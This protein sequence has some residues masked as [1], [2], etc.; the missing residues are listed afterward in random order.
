MMTALSSEVMPGQQLPTGS[1]FWARTFHLRIVEMIDNRKKKKKKPDNSS[2][3]NGLP[4]CKKPVEKP[5]GNWLGVNAVF[6]SWWVNE[7]RK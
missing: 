1:C 5:D 6:P 4:V 3:N 2:S 7:V